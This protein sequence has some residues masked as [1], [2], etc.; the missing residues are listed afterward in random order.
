ML[1]SE[2]IDGIIQAIQPGCRLRGYIE[3]RE[4]LNLPVAQA[5]IRLFY[6]EKSST[7]L[8]QELCSLSQGPKESYQDFLLRGLELRQKINFASK[9][10]INFA[11]DKKL[12]ERQL[13]NS[14]ITGIREESICY[15]LDSLLRN[16][17]SDEKLLENVNE[18]V[19]RQ[20]ERNNKL[21]IGKCKVLNVKTSDESEVLKELKSLRLEINE[22]K[23]KYNG[24]NSQVKPETVKK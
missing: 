8:Y 10:V 5:T 12:V 4:S 21:G 1:Q 3:G 19:R 14:L 6:H 24:S 18:V 15:E 11:Y 22:L 23:A 16:F 13:H 2:I 17:T 9:E 7:E 20:T